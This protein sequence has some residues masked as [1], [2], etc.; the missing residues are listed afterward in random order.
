MHILLRCKV[1]WLVAHEL[2]CVDAQ[3]STSDLD[4][5]ADI[6]VDKSSGQFIYAKY[7]FDE[8]A[9][10]PGMWSLERLRGLPAGL[11][12]VFTYVLG[13][14]QVRV[15]ASLRAWQRCCGMVN[16]TST[17]IHLDQGFC[18]WPDWNQATSH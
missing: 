6:I 8:L 16:G 18:N 1:A 15:Y 5:A 3:V 11:H 12:G 9:K 4:A 13:V 7:V 17:H 2:L 14:V 10:Q